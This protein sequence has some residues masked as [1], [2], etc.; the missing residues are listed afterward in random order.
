MDEL[1]RPI[2]V[3][4]TYTTIPSRYDVLKR[5]ILTLKEQTH[6]LDA[7]Y[8]TLPFKAKR[9]NKE[10]PPLP[11]D[12]AALCTVVRTEI[13][14]GPLT[15][16][17]GALISEKDPGTVIISCDDDVF[18]EPNHVESLLAHHETHPQS[19]I[20]G[21]GALIG[22]G[23]FFISIVS[24]VRPF[25]G[26][27]GFTGFEVDKRGHRVDLI[28]GV[29]GVLYTRGMFPS[30]E[31]LR[32]ELLRHSL[33]DDDI[34]LNDDVLISGYLS[35]KGIERRVFFDIPTI[36]HDNG[37]DALSSDIFK[38]IWRL[39]TAINKVRALGFFPTMEDVPLDETPAWR[40]FVTIIFVIA[41]I[42]LAVYLYQML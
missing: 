31:T 8:L 19:A 22:R 40:V 27:S 26:W 6:K 16:I 38:M 39:N 2:R 35:K 28:F 3:V 7:I 13:D 36:H 33:E 9:L 12:L 32:E 10:Y 15:K 41:I 18:F 21:T 30:N 4:A 34:F 23:L 24:T 37:S 14:Y 11:E 42:I 17:Y 1:P 25:H 5:S 20:C 29:A